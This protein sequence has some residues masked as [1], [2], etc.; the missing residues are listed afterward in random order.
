MKNGS[1][2][3][4]YFFARRGSLALFAE[5]FESVEQ[6]NCVCGVLS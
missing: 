6:E 1:Y 5:C 4:S 2:F 3:G